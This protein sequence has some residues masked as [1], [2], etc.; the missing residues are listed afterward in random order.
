VDD[1]EVFLVDLGQ[2]FGLS[3]GVGSALDTLQQWLADFF[4]QERLQQMLGQLG[5]FA[6]PASTF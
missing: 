1:I 6:P 5:T 2:R 3:V 4:D